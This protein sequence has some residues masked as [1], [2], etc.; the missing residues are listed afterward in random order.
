MHFHVNLR[1]EIGRIKQETIISNEILNS[2]LGWQVECLE[3]RCMSETSYGLEYSM[4]CMPNL[5]FI[6]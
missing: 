2:I 1:I 3:Y 6:G 4:P 5:N